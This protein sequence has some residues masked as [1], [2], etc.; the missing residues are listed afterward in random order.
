MVFPWQREVRLNIRKGDIVQR[1][2]HVEE[3]WLAGVLVV[4]RDVVEN[5]CESHILCFGRMTIRKIQN[6]NYRKY[7]LINLDY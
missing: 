1:L 6:N 4:L 5:V 3:I 7:Y 2:P